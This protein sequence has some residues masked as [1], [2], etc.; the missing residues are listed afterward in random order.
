MASPSPRRLDTLEQ[1][2]QRGHIELAIGAPATIADE[3]SPLQALGPEAEIGPV[4]VQRLEIIAATIDEDE[5][6]ARE[7]VLP[8]CVLGQCD[9]TREPRNGS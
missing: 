5:Q 1:Q 9:Q 8:E 6:V 2:L 4:E 3:P 7:R